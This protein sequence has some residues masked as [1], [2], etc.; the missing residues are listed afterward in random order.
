MI[1][2]FWKAVAATVGAA[3]FVVAVVVAAIVVAVSES[4]FSKD[5]DPPFL[6]AAQLL[7]KMFFEED[8]IGTSE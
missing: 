8:L 4:G 7:Q 1:N 5:F 3:V 2:T 6:M